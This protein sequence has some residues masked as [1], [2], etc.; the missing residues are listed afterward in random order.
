LKSCSILNSSFKTIIYLLNFEINEIFEGLRLGEKN[1]QEKKL[2]RGGRVRD[3]S[4][5]GDAILK[6]LK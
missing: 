4:P 3:I 1:S 6:K 5:Y 2:R